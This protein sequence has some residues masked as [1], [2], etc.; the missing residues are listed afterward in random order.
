MS[1]LLMPSNPI[2]STGGLGALIAGSPGPQVIPGL[3]SPT[4]GALLDPGMLNSP[5]SRRR[6]KSPRWAGEE[7]ASET[8]HRLTELPPLPGYCRKSPLATALG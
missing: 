8:D 2:S 4:S 7:G 1:T 6:K 3:A 5:N